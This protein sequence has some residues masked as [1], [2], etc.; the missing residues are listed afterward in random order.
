MSELSGMKIYSIC[1]L[2]FVCLVM[3][4]HSKSPLFQLIPSSQSH[5][6]FSNSIKENDT[7]N[8]FDVTNM[9]NG[10]GVGIGDFNND[11]LLDIYF[12]GNQVSSRLYLNK[13]SFSF[14]D[15][16]DIAKVDGNG[17]WCR[18]VA[19]VDINNDGRQDIYVCATIYDDAVRR[20]NLL[21]VNQGNNAD[22][23]PVFKEM[24]KEYGLDDDS[25]STM[26]TFFDYDNDGD[27]D[28][29]I[30]VNEIVENTN[31]SVYRKRITDGSWPSTGRLY[32]NDWKD[33]VGHAFFTN[34]SAQAGITVEGYGHSACIADF[35]R[36]GWK[37][38]FVAN[39]FLSNDILYINNHD[40]TFT[41][42][43]ASYFKHTSANGMGSDVID[44]NN[45]G[46]ADVI[47]MDM[48]PA[49]NYR[50]KVLMSG[51]KYL[52]Y[53][54][55]EAYGYQY[56]YVRNT[57][58][59]N[60]GPRLPGKDSIGEPVFGDVG[61]YAGVASTDWSWAPVVQDFDNDGQRDIIITNGFPKDLT[62]HDFIA[63]RQQSFATKSKREVLAAIPQVKLKNYA[64][65]NNGQ[66]QFTD[67]TNDWGFTALSFSN[68]A[69]YADLDNDGDLDLVVS[70]INDKAFI[71]Q[72]KSAEE[73]R[74]NSKFLEVQLAG[75]SLNREGIGAWV[76][77][78]YG[79]QHQVIENTPYRGFLSTMQPSLHFGLG[80]V[81]MVDSVRVIWPDN[82]TQMVRRVQARQT[83]RLQ[84]KNANAMY[85]W[86][87]AAPV[88]Q[89]LFTDVTDTVGLHYKH[90][91]HDFIDF[92][93]Q[94]L[95]PHKL[96]ENTPAIA[97]GDINGDGLD[98]IVV[99]GASGYSPT[100]FF[101][102]K[103]G[104]FIEKPL[105]PPSLIS[106][107]EATSIVLFDA[108]GDKDLDM[109]IAC[110][111]NEAPPGSADYQDKLFI[112]DGHGNFA[113]DT[114][115]LPENHTSK[116]CVRVADYDKDGDLD[117]F[118]A[119]RCYPFNYPKAVSS[120]LLR[121]DS[122]NGKVKFTDVTSTAAAGLADIG[123][124]CDAVWSDFDND[125]WPDLM[126]AGEWM[127]LKFFK[128][129]HGKFIDVSA[130]SGINDKH[131]WWTCI[132][133]GD[134]DNDGDEDYIVG[135]LGENSFYKAS[136]QYPVSV[137]A[138]DFYNQNTT[139]CIITLYL[140]DHLDGTLK[141]FTAHNRDDVV[142][143]LPFIKKRFLTYAAFGNATFDQ[144]LTKDELKNSINYTA[145]Y[146]PSAFIR[147]NGNGQFSIEPLPAAAQ[148]S[149]LSDMIT[150]DF[151][152]D[153]NLDVFINTN[154]FSG[155]P[156]NGRYDALNGLV[157]KGHGNGKFE[158][159]SFIQSGVNIPGNG[160]GLAV[161]KSSSGHL[162]MVAGQNRSDLKIF[163]L[164]NV[165]EK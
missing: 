50:K 118:I 33:S 29:Y 46:L 3:S 123:M 22:G 164:N 16:T 77:I 11:G 41:D 134:F 60:Q 87:P 126:L 150:G 128:N 165:L 163:R 83:L 18:G 103:S 80:S 68:G 66:V 53:Q 73:K 142:D 131:G 148:F 146:F 28:V 91:E 159:L 62:D 138:K 17:K 143:Q 129:D 39:D 124:I 139:Q 137:Y 37:D 56:Q 45:D 152:K 153:G 23:V 117:I 107:W 157:L 27:L 133:S 44:I 6:E 59:L 127:P 34:V 32:R 147:N 69:A 154:D 15:V 88:G 35:N 26:A 84:Q 155:D 102:Q 99:G 64:F 98:D 105:L 57:L 47:E 30:T 110:G 65:K 86:K 140:K 130:Q 119:G 81:E 74:E 79:S 149:A 160:K 8:P 95:I 4:C 20:K 93:I 121:N 94:K 78:Y 36:D 97:T 19:V 100:I 113:I 49:D 24:A 90:K 5:I 13:G 116:S 85:D 111:S 161:L 55:N 114:A 21:Y 92:D 2:C 31:P 104:K 12:A 9:Y 51:Y 158:P 14:Q 1:M 38:I 76:D 67:V 52:D 112:N 40:G 96:S 10:A 120:I 25:H 42:R 145:N 75:D 122:K 109:Y 136:D 43:S 135:N 132:T 125:G 144:L 70:N 58:Q 72:N 48:D 108:D 7:I 141:E 156:A 162:L 106:H 151:D 82:K 61:F 63:F 115:A 71:Y 101:Q 54:N 89:P